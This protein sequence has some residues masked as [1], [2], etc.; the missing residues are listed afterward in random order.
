MAKKISNFLIEFRKNVLNKS[1]VLNK[2][3]KKTFFD[4]VMIVIY[5]DCP[6]NLNCIFEKLNHIYD[7]NHAINCD[8]FDF[9]KALNYDR[10]DYPDRCKK[11]SIFIDDNLEKY[12]YINGNQY[13][14][15]GSKPLKVNCGFYENIFIQFNKQMIW[16]N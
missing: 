14:C 3:Y 6:R 16:F 4:E 10:Y 1:F 9:Y 12:E 13:L 2:S 5:I 11:Y 7:C 15:I 8:Y